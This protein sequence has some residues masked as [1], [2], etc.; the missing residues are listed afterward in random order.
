MRIKH[1]LGAVQGQLEPDSDSPRADVTNISPA[2]CT[3]GEEETGPAKTRGF[4][5]FPIPLRCSSIG[6]TEGFS[7]KAIG[8]P[9]QTAESILHVSAEKGLLL[10]ITER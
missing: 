8:N 7:H 1:P 2:S 10:Y 4:C 5:Y 9:Y 3:P 6:L